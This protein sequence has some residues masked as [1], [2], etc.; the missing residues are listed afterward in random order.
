MAICHVLITFTHLADIT[1]TLLSKA[2]H[3]AFKFFS[4]PVHAL[5]GNR[6]CDAATQHALL[7]EER[8]LVLWLFFYL[9]NTHTDGRSQSTNPELKQERRAEPFSFSHMS[10][11]TA[12]LFSPSPFRAVTQRPAQRAGER[13]VC[14]VSSAAVSGDWVFEGTGWGRKGPRKSPAATRK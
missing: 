10:R 6:T 5:P 7:N 14:V 13:W 8:L 9:T 3:C 11:Q 1:Y 4:L 2:T 12:G